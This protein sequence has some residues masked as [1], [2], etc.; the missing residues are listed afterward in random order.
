MLKHDTSVPIQMHYILYDAF[1]VFCMYK[2]H[3]IRA[4]ARINAYNLH[5]DII[6]NEKMIVFDNLGRG[7]SVI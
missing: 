6:V 7:L 5:Q 4:L 1:H 3:P 2:I